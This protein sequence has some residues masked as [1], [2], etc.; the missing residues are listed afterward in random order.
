MKADTVSLIPSKLYTLNILFLAGYSFI[1]YYRILYISL[2][3]DVISLIIETS[4][5]ILF[6]G[7]TPTGYEP[8]NI[9]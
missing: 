9:D 6:I 5:N 1:L 2:I 3:H 7:V 8:N 4:I